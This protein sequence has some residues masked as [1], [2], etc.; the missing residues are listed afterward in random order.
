[1]ILDFSI[2]KK[3]CAKCGDTGNM[4]LMYKAYNGVNVYG[5]DDCTVM[6]SN[7]KIEWEADTFQC[8][9]CEELFHTD[10]SCE[11]DC[12]GYTCCVD[13]YSDHKHIECE[14]CGR[15]MYCYNNDNDIHETVCDDCI[16]ERIERIERERE[17][18]EV[19][20]E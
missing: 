9:I 18:S 10:E 2:E 12:C 6:L 13:C 8:E 5:C 19:E 15:Y 20:P 1:M 17:D 7:H 4:H 11:L 14:D 3:H 16:Q